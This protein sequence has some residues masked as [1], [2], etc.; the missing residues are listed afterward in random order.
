LPSLLSV[1]GEE[2]EQDYRRVESLQSDSDTPST[3]PTGALSPAA[4]EWSSAETTSL[5]DRRHSTSAIFLATNGG[6]C[7]T[8]AHL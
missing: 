5:C 7:K 1:A 2:S 8:A 3:Q 4:L 6:L